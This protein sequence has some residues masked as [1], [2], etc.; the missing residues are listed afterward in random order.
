MNIVLVLIITTIL[1]IGAK[2]SLAQTMDEST[3]DANSDTN[4]SMEG[5][6]GMDHSS[7]GHSSMG[8]SS[9]DHSSM[10]MDNDST[11]DPENGADQPMDDDSMPGTDHNRMNHSS[12]NQSRMNHSSTDHS[13]MDHSNVHSM[14]HESM[15]PSSPASPTM[16]HNMNQSTAAMSDM[17]G[18]NHGSM[19]GGSAPPDARDPHAYADGFDFG[20]IPRPRMGDEHY[21]GALLIDRLEAARTSDNTSAAYALKGWYGRDYDRT[22]LKAEG[23]IDNGKLQ[24]ARS[25]LFWGHAVSAYWNTLLGL[26]HDSGEEPS[27]SWL[28]LGIQGLAPYWFEMD[29][30]AYVG[31]HG[32]LALNLEAEYELAITQKLIL[33]PRIETDLYSKSDSE[34]GIGSG[35]SELA[36][37]LRL[38]YEIRRQ[39]AP[40]IGIERTGLFGGTADYARDAGLDTRETRA[41]AG[42]RA[43]F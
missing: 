39:F 9:M 17:A 6:E 32:R 40:Y 24:E 16:D 14:D 34:R 25:Q 2:L 21:F 37:G 19:Q 27:R 22:I 18:M 8:H 20:P 41:V 30:T 43:W 31:E 33:Q 23:D 13:G 11:Q 5:M 7:M 42:V 29:I 1:T 35:L 28:A 10:P 3:A 38:R 36:A 12:M 4:S 26:R 15:S